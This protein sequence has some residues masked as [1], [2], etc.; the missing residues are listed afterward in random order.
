MIIT[1]LLG[2]VGCNESKQGW[3]IQVLPAKFLCP[4]GVFA[5]FQE[6]SSLL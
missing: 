1:C 5:G 6:F 2:I 4:I 3:G